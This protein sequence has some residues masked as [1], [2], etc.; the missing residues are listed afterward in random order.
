MDQEQLIELLE[1]SIETVNNLE[2]KLEDQ[3][4]KNKKM[5]ESLQKQAGLIQGENGEGLLEVEDRLEELHNQQTMAENKMALIANAYVDFESD[6]IERINNLTDLNDDIEELK[7]QVLTT[8]LS[9]VE[10]NLHGLIDNSVRSIL[11]QKR[12]SLNQ[13]L[14]DMEFEFDGRM[15]KILNVEEVVNRQKSNIYKGVATIVAIGVI[16]IYLLQ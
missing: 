11:K 14:D 10:N 7:N 8:A 1:E 4:V 6:V 15:E 16:S 9:S 5:M 2:N 12:T 13:K 3:I